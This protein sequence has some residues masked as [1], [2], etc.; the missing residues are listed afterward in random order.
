M[1]G[2]KNAA[3]RRLPF[4][5]GADDGLSF[6]EC[7]KAHDVQAVDTCRACPR[8]WLVHKGSSPETSFVVCDTGQAFGLSGVPLESGKDVFVAEIM[9]RPVHTITPTSSIR[10]LIALLAAEGINGVP[11][12]EPN[13][14]LVGSATSADVISEWA[15]AQNEAGPVCSHEASLMNH[16]QVRPVSSVMTTPAIKIASFAS[17]SDVALLMSQH[18][19]QQ[20]AVVNESDHLVGV[21]SYVDVVTWVANSGQK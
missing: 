8:C 16:F 14:R 3:L 12:V 7:P 2:F 5:T 15:D 1:T 13:G 11:V 17:V 20:V 10:Q 21:V 18:M 19:A 9:S 4:I 6:V